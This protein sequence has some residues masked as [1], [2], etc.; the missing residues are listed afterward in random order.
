[1]AEVF[2]AG[3][4]PS[5]KDV[6]RGAYTSLELSTQ[7]RKL[8]SKIQ[9]ALAAYA[10]GVNRFIGEGKLPKA[11]ADNGFS[12]DPWTPE[13]SAAIAIRMLQTFGRGGAGEIRN[14]AL[15]G[16]MQTQSALKG[17]EEEVLNDL[18]WFNDPLAIPT[19]NDEDVKSHM[20]FPPPSAA[21]T[22]AHL[23]MLPKAGLLELLPG[24]RVV[25]KEESTRV[26]ATVS[27]PYKSGSYC[28]VAAPK[29]SASGVPLLLSGPQM[30]FRQ[31]SIVH[32]MSIDAPG[33]RAVGMDIPGV[34]GVIVGHTDHFAWG[35]TTGVA[36]TED[37]FFAKQEGSNFLFG[38]QSKPISKVAFNLKVK[39]GETTRVEQQRTEWGPIVL[40]LRSGTVFIRRSTFWKRELE[41]FE[42]FFGLYSA[43][44]PKEIVATTDK[45]TL[46]FNF[47][48]ATTKGDIGHRYVGNVPLRSPL[49]DPRFPTPADPK[50]DWKGYI[51]KASMPQVRNPKSGLIVNWNNKPVSWW[52]NFDT[53]VWGR[54]FRND[55]LLGGLAKPKLS[56]ADLEKTIYEAARTDY[57]F[58]AFKS[59]LGVSGNLALMGY[60][61][62]IL[63]G[64]KNA[65][66]YLAFFD[67][68]RVEIFGKSIG[69]LI[70]PD[71]FK[72]ALQPS[73]MLNALDGKTKF[74]FLGTRSR[75]EV[76]A[77]AIETVEE[78]W[79]IK[80]LP[81]FRVGRIAV[82]G[83]EPILYSDRGTYIQI[84]ELLKKP[85]GRNV[86]PP[87]IAESGPHRT[88]QAEL[89]RN[90]K[91]K[92]M[93]F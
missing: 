82:E 2:G 66:F 23:A 51:P 52:P 36:D 73:L 35:L 6:L 68:L 33:I 65:Q 62:K 93:G 60:D 76:V 38:A 8:S 89:A 4:L 22:S 72:Q 18:A 86:L 92:P 15:L 40:S 71:N 78:N 32:E 46:N 85:R 13:D 14:M 69:S 28:I 90:W 64:S 91:Y 77:A 27:A 55:V 9:T 45:A 50:F 34:P 1:M 5:D 79:K 39:G 12:P 19:I 3:L 41:S 56:T 30:G 16:Y 42:A 25:M 37:I 75:Q 43:K 48:Y 74:N 57:N 67:A 53:P 47:F 54:I 11:Y 80:E 58:R 84:V 10:K 49:V 61:G 21:L 26:A 29:R 70:S 88:D 44:T 87:G 59:I 83:E 63:E 24:L 7:V 81:Q 17:H 31:P 20:S